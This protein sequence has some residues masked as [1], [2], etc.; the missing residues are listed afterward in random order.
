MTPKRPWCALICQRAFAFWVPP[1]ELAAGFVH[2]RWPLTCDWPTTP[3]SANR[4]PVHFAFGQGNHKGARLCDAHNITPE[5]NPLV[6]PV[7]VVGVKAPGGHVAGSH[8]PMF[9]S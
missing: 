1:V 3:A 8:S 7:G 6:G 9:S 4:T 5:G 2:R